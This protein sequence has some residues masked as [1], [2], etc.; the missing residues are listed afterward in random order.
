MNDFKQLFIDMLA[1]E[2]KYTTQSGLQTVQAGDL[3]LIDAPILQDGGSGFISANSVY[4]RVAL[5]GPI[6]FSSLSYADLQ[7]TALWVRV[8]GD[9]DIGAMFPNFGN[10]SDSN[11]SATGGIIVT[12]QVNAHVSASISGMT[13]VAGGDVVVSAT[14][15]AVLLAD[16]EAKVVSAG[17]SAWGTGTAVSVNGQIA[18]NS[19]QNSA[20]AEI[21]ESS[22]TADGDVTVTAYQRS[23]LDSRVTSTTTSGTS[24][25][26]VT[27]AFNSIGWNTSNL[28]SQTLDVLIGDPLLT[29]LEGVPG[30]GALARIVNSGVDAGGDLTIEAISATRLNSTT[31]NSTLSESK[32]LVQGNA[33]ASALMLASNKVRG[34]TSAYLS[35]SGAAAGVVVNTGGSVAVT[36]SDEQR[37]FANNS[38]TSGTSSVNDGG[39]S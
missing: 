33:S 27:L 37:F 13:V 38:L 26:G 10:L 6:D 39:A 18:T 35:N 4:K 30:A 17:G 36:A 15:V 20:T 24:S 7:N 29:A 23:V 14:A 25:I 2:Y 11:S 32:A 34:G 22:V 28:F 12:N 1:D 19:V 5:G 8:N 3:V 9:I 16:L 21:L 31:S